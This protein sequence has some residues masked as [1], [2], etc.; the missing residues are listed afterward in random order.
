MVLAVELFALLP[1]ARCQLSAN[2]SRANGVVTVILSAGVVTVTSILLA[3]RAWGEAMQS[4]LVAYGFA[5]VL[6]TLVCPLCL[7]H[8]QK[9]KLNI[10]GPWDIAHVIEDAA[11]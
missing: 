8:I 6:I 9:R 1:E 3:L 10:Q 5:V 11:G 4:T 2:H 7:V